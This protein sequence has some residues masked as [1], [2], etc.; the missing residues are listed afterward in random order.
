MLKTVLHDKTAALSNGNQIACDDLVGVTVQIEG[1]TSSVI[2][3]EG[4]VNENNW[5][6]VAALVRSGS[7]AWTTTAN[8]NGIYTCSVAGL[9]RFRC[10]V[11]TYGGGD[12]ITVIAKPF[13]NGVI[14]T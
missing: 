9:E 4:T 6:A 11:S 10:R 12:Q 13:G 14:S 7:P 1:L 3:F 5:I 8:T 2:T